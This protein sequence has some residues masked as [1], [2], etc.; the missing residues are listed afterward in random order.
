MRCYKCMK[1]G[2]MME[3]YPPLKTK[4][5]KYKH[6]KAM[7]KTWDEIKRS[8]SGE[9]SDN[10]EALICSMAFEKIENEANEIEVEE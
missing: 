3:N 2:H 10:E 4:L 1:L 6:K 5:D 7:Y 8:D 9:D